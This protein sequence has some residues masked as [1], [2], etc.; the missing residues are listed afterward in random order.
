MQ[1]LRQGMTVKTQPWKIPP[2]FAE[3]P[4]LPEPVEPQPGNFDRMPPKAALE[5]APAPEVPVAP[6]GAASPTP[7]PPTPPAP[8]A[9]PA[10]P[11]N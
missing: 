11:A 1:K 9:S 5:G 8:A 7:A 6:A 3:D 4:T 2:G 10:A